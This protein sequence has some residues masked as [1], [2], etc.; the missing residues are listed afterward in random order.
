MN[1]Y[2]ELTEN[3]RFKNDDSPKMQLFLSKARKGIV[4]TELLTH[5]NS[6]IMITVE[7]A[8]R[9]AGPNAIWVTHTNAEVN[10]FNNSDFKLK[11]KDGK[12]HFRIV[13]RHTP[14]KSGWA[15]PNADSR[16]KLYQISRKNKAP[17]HLDLAMGSRVSCNANLGTQIGKE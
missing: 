2:H 16:M 1:E 12:T 5:M 3:V 17:T 6:R 7:E 9:K 13:S 14:S 4:N 8:K 10:K 11:V 15:L